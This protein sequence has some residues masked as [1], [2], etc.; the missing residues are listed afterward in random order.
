[1]LQGPKNFIENRGELLQR[2]DIS[3]VNLLL[4]DLSAHY[5]EKTYDGKPGMA[6]RRFRHAIS[7]FVSCCGYCA[8]MIN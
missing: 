6:V 3:V 1:M 2:L 7:R 8:D 4:A 5:R